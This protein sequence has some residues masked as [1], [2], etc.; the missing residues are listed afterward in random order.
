[1][2]NRWCT[3]CSVHRAEP[4]MAPHAAEFPKDHLDAFY[5][6]YAWGQRSMAAGSEAT[7]DH[8]VAWGFAAVAVCDGCGRKTWD[9]D[10]IGR[11]CGVPGLG[12]GGT[13]CPG[14]FVETAGGERRP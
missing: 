12:L 14:V 9:V 1:M 4:D 2:G 5:A 10:N 7:R 8:G 6:G 13:R 11:D 3:T